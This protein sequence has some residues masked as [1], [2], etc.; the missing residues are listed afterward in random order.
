[1]GSFRQNQTK[2]F[3]IRGSATYLYVFVVIF[4]SK[5]GFLIPE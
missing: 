4:R 1:M 3:K 2:T 5:E